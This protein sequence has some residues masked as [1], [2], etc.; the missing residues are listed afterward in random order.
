MFCILRSC[1]YHIYKV[2]Y[3]YIAHTWSFVYQ[4][5]GIDIDKQRACVCFVP[6]TCCCCCFYCC[7]LFEQGNF[8][9]KKTYKKRLWNSYYTYELNCTDCFNFLWSKMYYNFQFYGFGC[10]MQVV[11]YVLETFV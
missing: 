8:V 11:N 5:F 7:L 2:S 1:I 3:L 10:V 6:I 4:L 9:S